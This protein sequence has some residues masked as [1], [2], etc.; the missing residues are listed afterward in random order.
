MNYKIK[1]NYSE[2]A[3][4]LRPV[5]NIVLDRIRAK[6]TDKVYFIKQ[7]L[8][9]LILVIVAFILPL[10]TSGDVTSSIVV[11]PLGVWLLVTKEKLMIW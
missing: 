11:L 1:E 6:Q 4:S 5:Q 7:K 10:L 2:P 9:G 8:C 3:Y